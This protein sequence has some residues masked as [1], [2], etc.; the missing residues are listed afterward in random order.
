MPRHEPDLA[1]YVDAF[2]ELKRSD[3]TI[4]ALARYWFEGE[5]PTQRAS[6]WSVIRNVL[7]WVE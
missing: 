2:V 6:R 4:R 3:G 5:S 1:D 7:G